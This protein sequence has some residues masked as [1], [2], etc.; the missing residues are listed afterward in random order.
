MNITNLKNHNFYLF[1]E[2]L[3]KQTFESMGNFNEYMFLV[4][5]DKYIDELKNSD[6]KEENSLNKKYM[7]LQEEILKNYEKEINLIEN[8]KKN[9]TENNIDS[10]T[11]K[12]QNKTEKENEKDKKKGDEIVLYDFIS[13]SICFFQLRHYI[14]IKT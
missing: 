2:L 13:F 8:N 9:E 11:D 14:N 3:Y 12:K 10:G 6:K 5:N 4:D 1:G 7:E